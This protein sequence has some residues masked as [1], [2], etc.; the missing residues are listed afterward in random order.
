MDGP[1]RTTCNGHA[2]FRCVSEAA[3]NRQWRRPRRRRLALAPAKPIPASVAL[4]SPCATALR[5]G[6]E[7][8]SAQR[9]LLALWALLR[10]ERLAACC[11]DEVS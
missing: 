7:A 1:R 10:A 2:P 6:L 5:Q 4:D 3:R 8:L 11:G 9:P